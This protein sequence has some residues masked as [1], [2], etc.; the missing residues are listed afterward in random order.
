MLLHEALGP[1]EQHPQ[2]MKKKIDVSIGASC[3][4]ETGA[5]QT[6]DAIGES[7]GECLTDAD[8]DGICD[9]NNGD[10]CQQV[11]NGSPCSIDPQS[12]LYNA[13]CPK[14]DACGVCGGSGVDADADGICDDVDDCIGAVDGCGVCNGD[15][16]TCTGCTDPAASNYSVDNIFEDNGQCLYATTFNVDMNCFDN[17][18]ASV[19]GATSFT[20]VFVTGPILGWAAND[21]Y[22]ALTDADGDGIYSV[23]L[24]FPAGTIEY[25]YGINGFADQ[26]NL[27]DDMQNGGD[28]APVTDYAGYANRQVDAGTTADDTYGSGPPAELYAAF[29]LMRADCAE[30]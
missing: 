2:S 19:N 29:D 26:E 30:R 17:A 22:N 23:T 15:G 3:K 12:D 21:G 28:C 6:L 9:D 25:K 5:C 4:S 1:P 24:D 14:L 20:D 7:G 18:G 13:L 8:E 27:V 10:S 11:Y 16:T